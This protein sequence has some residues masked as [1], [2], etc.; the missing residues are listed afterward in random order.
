M[1]DL[2]IIVGTG[3]AHVFTAPHE[4]VRAN[5]EE[6]VRHALDSAERW[7]DDG[8]WI[9]GYRS[10]EGALTIGAFG[11]P[12]TMELEPVDAP[13]HTL[14][15]AS[16]DLEAYAA[17][18]ATLQRAI[19]DGDV[20]QVNYTF[21]FAFATAGDPFALWSH[22]A[23]KTGAA[24]Q[25]YVEDG[26]TAILSWSPELF[27]EIDGRRIVAKPMKGTAP[28]DRIADLA[29]PKNRAEHV[30]IV[31]LLRND[32][33]RI[34]DE[35]RVEK[36]FVNE[37]YPT[38]ATMTSTIA[39]RLHPASRLHEI[40]DA[41]FPSG[42]VTGAP[43]RAAMH[44]IAQTERHPRGVYC[45]TVGW[46]SPKRKGWWNVAI[47]TAQIDRSSGV[48]RFD[49]G[50]AIVADSDPHEEWAE[51]ALKARFLRPSARSFELWDT[52][53]SDADAATVAAHLARIDAS[54]RAF[55]VRYDREALL[56]AVA[57][58]TGGA[59]ALLRLRIAADGT[60]ATLRN[61]LERPER[62]LVG[63]SPARVHS[64]DPFLRHKTSWHPA[65][66]RARSWAESHD[67][68]D[69]LILNERDELTEGWRTNLFVQIGETLFTPPLASGVLP[70]ILRER[71]V[72]EGR[73]R[74]RILALDDLKRADAIFVGN[75]ARGLIRADLFEG[76]ITA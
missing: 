43:K 41:T 23:S 50:G 13:A 2:R 33:Q 10:Y 52:L 54:A 67:C 56:R 14:P 31:D 39:A 6:A 21:P 7:L 17:T 38:F 42:S 24:Y 44:F 59:P 60:I 51:I 69:A 61:A 20:Y 72:S 64:G 73:A 53:A 26:D 34:G 49:A 66:D 16:I 68:F 35:V 58:A 30:M 3:P 18:L 48:G 32:L 28:L 4:V 5:G 70:G 46:L 25:A 76:S 36:L 57:T 71:I 22:Y 63:I 37:R 62:V 27:L 9:A 40:F 65:H 47:R 19:A 12:A 45:G 55:G 1:N 74:E 15:L 8:L 11:A 75:S 29:S